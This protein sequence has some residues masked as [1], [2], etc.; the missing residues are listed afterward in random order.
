MAKVTIKDIHRKGLHARFAKPWGKC[1]A[2]VLL[3]PSAVGLVPASDDQLTRLATAGLAALA[4]DPYSAYDPAMPREERAKISETVLMDSD[5]LREQSGWIDIM[6]NKLGLASLG[7]LGFC[8]GGRMALLLAAAD[9]RVKAA[10]AFYPTMRDPR[11]ANAIDLPPVADQI[12]CPVQV[13]Y[14]GKDHLT[15]HASLQRLRAALD[16]R[17]A[18]PPAAVIHYP[19]ARHGFLGKTQEENP[20]DFESGMTSWAVTT[21]FFTATLA[22]A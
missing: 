2:G 16:A 1:S 3:L 18:V 9:P 11:P 20:A 14:P 19:Q 12:I 17:Q 5:A 15:S 8:M 4:W 21:A 6:Q 7:V 13:H 22:P 10:A